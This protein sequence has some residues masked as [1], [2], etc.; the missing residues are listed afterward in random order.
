MILR[1]EEKKQCWTSHGTRGS[2]EL[3]FQQGSL[4]HTGKFEVSRGN[5][6]LSNEKNLVGWGI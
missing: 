6:H 5:H 1:E 4:P 2:I 3:Y